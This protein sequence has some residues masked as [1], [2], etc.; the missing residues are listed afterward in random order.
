MK[1]G[2]V[3]LLQVLSELKAAGKSSDALSSLKKVRVLIND[4][5]EI[6]SP[7]SKP[8]F[9]K[10]TRGISNA[11]IFEP[12]LS[13]GGF[14]SSHSG[15]HWM[16]LTVRG[17][18]AHAGLEHNKGVNACVELGSKVFKM[19]QLTD[20]SKQLTVNVGFIH[21]G[22][23][24][25]VVC[26]EA[27]A[28]VDIRYR[29]ASDLKS[30]LAK[31]DQIKSETVVHNPLLNQRPTAELSVLGEVPSMSESATVELLNRARKFEGELG[32]PIRAQ[33]VGYGSDGGPLE[34]AGLNVLV[35]L[36]PYGEGMHTDQEFMYAE[37]YNQRLKL[38]LILIRSLLG[39]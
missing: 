26:E 30:V 5:E 3:L 25:N 21:G 6:G 20:Y 23:K 22:I 37:S 35:G 11:L 36:G 2:V 12:G 31:L 16:E 14:A 29:D 1:G 19:S 4:D 15:V 32:Y 34:A 39:L 27:H 18:A 10:F 33:H 8:H 28:K 38:S 9:S 7:Y 17:K 13:D 24:P